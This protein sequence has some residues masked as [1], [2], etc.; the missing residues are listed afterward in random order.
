MSLTNEQLKE[1]VED[2]GKGSKYRVAYDLMMHIQHESLR[3]EAEREGENLGTK[4]YFLKLYADCLK[5]ILD[6]EKG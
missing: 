5:T 1:I 4:E 6:V 2:L 3:T